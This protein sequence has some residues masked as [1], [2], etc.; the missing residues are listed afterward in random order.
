MIHVLDKRGVRVRMLVADWDGEPSARI[1]YTEFGHTA[2]I[3]LI[4]LRQKYPGPLGRVNAWMK[5]FKAV[6]V[7]TRTWHPDIIHLIK[8]IGLPFLLLAWKYF[9]TKVLGR[10]ALPAPI[11]LD[12]DDLE[13]AWSRQGTLGIIWQMLGSRA[14]K[15]AWTHADAVIAASHYLV[16]IIEKVRGDSRVYLVPNIAPHIETSARPLSSRRLLIPTRLLDIRPETM[17][18]WLHSIVQAIPESN[19]LIVGPSRKDSELLS[20]LTK[21]LRNHVAVLSWQTEEAY[22]RLLQRPP[23]IGFYA[24]EDTPAARAKS[25]A[26]LLSMMAAGVPIVATDVGE[27]RYL[28]GDAGVVVPPVTNEIVAQIRSLWHD[29]ERLLTLGEKARMR[30]RQMF[31]GDD[32][33]QKLALAYRSVLGEEKA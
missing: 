19:I 11:I 17:T 32:L 2:Q 22:F 30:A 33:A 13:S 12:C 28:L 20:Q 1:G 14:E 8:P 29:N 31:T 5:M 27:P 3:Y 23:R 10:N 25:P 15:W 24:V 21:D 16:D 26:R 9:Q 4:P 6:W 18:T 7:L